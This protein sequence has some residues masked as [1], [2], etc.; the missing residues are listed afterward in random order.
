MAQQ[1][2]ISVANASV[3]PWW[4]QL[5]KITAQPLKYGR[6][7]FVF[8]CVFI[9]IQIE[10]RTKKLKIKTQRGVFLSFMMCQILS[11]R[12]KWSCS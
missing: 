12:D 8:L 11:A 6:K 4:T 2:Y 10:V 5:T 3:S 9:H 1:Q 7:H